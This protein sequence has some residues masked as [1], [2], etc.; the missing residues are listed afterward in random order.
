MSIDCC[1][2]TVSGPLLLYK[3]L[4]RAGPAKLP[5]AGCAMRLHLL[6][7]RGGEESTRD[8]QIFRVACHPRVEI[9]GH[10]GADRPRFIVGYGG[11]MVHI[12][13]LDIW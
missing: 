5:G 11:S 7:E 8:L 13:G 10:T 4:H 9:Q 1:A 12:F 3:S 2:D 6:D